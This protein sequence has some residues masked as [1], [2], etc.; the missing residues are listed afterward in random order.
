MLAFTVFFELL[1]T[2]ETYRVLSY[3]E[4]SILTGCVLPFNTCRV[5]VGGIEWY[6][7]GK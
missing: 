1:V 6:Q 3:K 4:A 5:I 7:S 2:Q